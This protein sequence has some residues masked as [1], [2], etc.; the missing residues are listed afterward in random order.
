MAISLVTGS[1]RGIGLELCRQ[2]VARGDT[3]IATCRSA[4][5]ELRSLPVRVEEGVEVADEASVRAFAGR[6]DAPNIDLLILN[7]GTSN[8]DLIFNLDFSAVRRQI[9]VNALG[10]LIVTAVLL[11]RLHTGSKVA[12]ISSRMGSIEGNDG[13]GMYGYRMSKAAMNAAGRSLALDLRPL[14]IAVA[15]LHPGYV[16]TELNYYSG[17]I[18]P[19]E[20]VTGVLAR[21]DELTLDTSGTFRDYQGATLPW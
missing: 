20:S 11:N 15:I 8:I 3:V 19:A 1:S 2:L 9:E 5:A 10:A 17:N 7:A 18:S 4:T 6:L 16:A 14:G 21:I 13:G 12:L